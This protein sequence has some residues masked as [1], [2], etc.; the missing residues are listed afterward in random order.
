MN[1]ALSPGDAVSHYRVVGKLGEGGMGSVWLAEDLVLGRRVALKLIRAEDESEVMRQRLLREARAASRLTHPNIC[2][3]YEAGIVDGEPFIA[4]QYIDGQ[5]LDHRLRDPLPVDEILRVASGVAAGLA[6]AHAQKI[7]HRDIKPQNVMLTERAVVI[8]DFGLAHAVDPLFDERLTAKDLVSGTAPYMSPEQLRRAEA[9]GKSDVFSLGV[10]LYELVAGRRPFDRPSIADTIAAILHETPAPLPSRGPRIAAL[11]QLIV[12][13]L[14]KNPAERPEAAEVLREVDHIRTLA[15]ASNV[16]TTVVPAAFVTEG[17]STAA[18]SRPVSAAARVDPEASKLYLRARQ[19]SK[20]RSPETVRTA[21][22]LLQN[23]IEIEPEYAPAYAALAD[24]YTFLGYLQVASPESVF[25]K[26]RAAVSRAIEIDPLLAEAHA[27]RGWIET[28]YGWKPVEAEISLREAIR[29]DPNL[30]PAHHW[31]GLF[32]LIRER[33]TE[34]E[35]SLRK[36]A[37]IDP[38]SPIFGTACAFPAMQRGDE[39]VAIAMYH[40]ILDSEP[41]FVPVR[42][43]LGLALERAGRV[44]EAIEQFRRADEMIPTPME[45]TPALAHAL[46]R[47]GAREEAEAVVRRM[48]D[49]ARDR[50]I[51]PVFFAVAAVGAG[52]DAEA[53]DQLDRAVEI[54]AMRLA[55]LHLDARFERLRGD[56]SRLEAILGKVGMIPAFPDSGM[57]SPGVRL[58]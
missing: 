43:Y 35:A 7:V 4:M 33:L 8:L 51:S 14:R 18:T 55:D 23:A 16:A 26:A 3:I 53:L 31:L 47:R 17:A 13:M 40:S 29:L 15:D 49:A 27:T 19:M 37:E 38:L 2:T 20:K 24:C 57:P 36:A 12:R 5:A 34:A 52:N 32:L 25:P 6:E 48:H 11:E 56:G 10:M 54:R 58:T 22:G 50:F 45:A 28:V 30:A 21:I 41:A 42:F 9:D 46:A 44:D 39:E 1:R